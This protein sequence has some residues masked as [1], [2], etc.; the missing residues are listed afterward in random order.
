VTYVVVIVAVL[1]AAPAGVACKET[2][3]S[4]AVDA[5]GRLVI[6]TSDDRRIVVAKTKDQ[7]TFEKPILSSSR[8]AVGATADFPNCCTSYDIPL[9]LVVYSGGKVHR[10][11]GMG[12]PIFTWQFS[13]AG[14]R[15]AYSQETVH[16]ACSVH[17][18][19]RDIASERLL[20]SADVPEPC[21]Q[22]P[23]PDMNVRIP[24]WVARLRSA[25]Q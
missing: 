10:F 14:S 24:D 1:A 18:E 7:T 25:K 16:F 20:D 17:Y 2:Y 6:H 9:E 12:L 22:E 19:L 23:N 21:G 11:R 15:V 13:D 5:A 3:R 4:A 8:T